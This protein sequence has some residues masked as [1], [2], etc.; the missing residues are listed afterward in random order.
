MQSLLLPKHNS[1]T[2]KLEKDNEID[3]ENIKQFILQL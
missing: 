3:S 2:L 1:V